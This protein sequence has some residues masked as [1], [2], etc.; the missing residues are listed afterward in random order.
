MVS[1]SVG[2]H[3]SS[4]QGGTNRRR[5]S[6]LH[7]LR[8]QRINLLHSSRWPG[9]TGIPA[10]TQAIWLY[11]SLRTSRTWTDPRIQRLLLFQL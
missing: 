11:R 1:H 9:T 10:T 4:A 8:Q 6:V 7:S 2:T 5:R 3:I